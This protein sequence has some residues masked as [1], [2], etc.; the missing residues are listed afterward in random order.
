MASGIIGIGRWG[1]GILVKS[2][3]SVVWKQ[4]GPADWMVVVVVGAMHSVVWEQRRLVVFGSLQP[5]I[6]ALLDGYVVKKREDTQ[7]SKKAGGGQAVV[8]VT[9]LL[10]HFSRN[11]EIFPRRI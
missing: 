3:R 2:S 4:Q 11:I 7:L 8:S 9:F 6:L 1:R 5:D 10:G